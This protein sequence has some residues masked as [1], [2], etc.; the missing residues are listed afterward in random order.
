M[1]TVALPATATGGGL[2]GAVAS[3]WTK[4]WTVRSTWWCLGS[5]IA[6]MGLVSLQMGFS[7]AYANTHL[8][9]GELPR[10]MP[11]GDIVVTSV[12]IVQ[13]V[14]SALAMLMITTEY[15]TGSIRSTLQW[16]PVRRNVLLAKAIVLAPVVFVLGLVLGGVGA[17]I[18]GIGLGEWATLEPAGLVVD[19]LSV[20]AYLTLAGLIT[21]SLGVLIRSAAGTLT[22]AFLLLLLIPMMLGQSGFTILEWTAALLPGGAGQNFISGATE[23][24]SPTTSV[25]VLLAWAGAGLV[26]GVRTL[27]SRDA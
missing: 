20:A 3:E 15:S 27:Q 24:V 23:P 9:P 22:A 12:G 10:M 18:G 4:L 11:V 17:A 16:T 25:L 19:L 8:Q 13:V 6:M 7:G 1:T 2:P 26:A 21:V 5:S 14:V